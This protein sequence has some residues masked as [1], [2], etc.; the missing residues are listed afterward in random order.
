MMKGPIRPSESNHVTFW[1]L[2]CLL[3]LHVMVEFSQ[4]RHDY[5]HFQ[6]S[7]NPITVFSC[8]QNSATIA[9]SAGSFHHQ[10]SL[11]LELNELR[12]SSD[13]PQY[14]FIY[15]TVHILPDPPSTKACEKACKYSSAFFHAGENSRDLEG[16]SF[17]HLT[18]TPIKNA[19]LVK[20]TEK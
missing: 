5:F 10:R 8:Q 1:K 16:N 3:K 2:V 13:N 9:D 12:L 4:L 17:T 11:I 20:Y 6:Q 14:D 18:G 15:G 19:L 7:T